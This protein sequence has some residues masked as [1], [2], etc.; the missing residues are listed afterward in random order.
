MRYKTSNVQRPSI[1]TTSIYANDPRVCVCVCVNQFPPIR[2]RIFCVERH[3][4]GSKAADKKKEKKERERALYGR[5]SA[6]K[7]STITLPPPPHH[8]RFSRTRGTSC[9]GRSD[10]SFSFW[11]LLSTTGR[12]GV[13]A[14]RS[15]RSHTHTHT[16]T[17]N[18]DGRSRY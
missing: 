7:Q 11:K 12:R 3:P 6:P 5:L 8:G 14:T 9:G 4:V 16:H 15:T 10:C 2:L 13:V 18:K 1:R 17:K